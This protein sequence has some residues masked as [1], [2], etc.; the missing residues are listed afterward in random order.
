MCAT[1]RHTEDQLAGRTTSSTGVGA[2]AGERLLPCPVFWPERE[3]HGVRYMPLEAEELSPEIAALMP[4]LRSLAALG[5]ALRSLQARDGTPLSS[6]AADA[7][8][9]RTGSMLM[10]IA[11]AVQ[12]ETAEI[13][14]LRAEALLT[15]GSH[16][17]AAVREAELSQAQ[18]LTLICGP[19][20][21]FRRKT[22]HPLHTVIAA[23]RNR[24]YDELVTKLD[25]HLEAATVSIRAELGLSEL[26]FGS[27]F[28]MCVTDLI[29]CGGEANAYPKHF[30]YFLPE[31]EGIA[32]EPGQRKKTVVF[33]NVYRYRHTIISQPLGEALLS[34]PSR[35]AETPVERIL[36]MW[37][38]GHDIGHGA[39]LP[40][41]D[42]AWEPD[43]G[44]EPFMMIQEAL[45]DVFG[46][47]LAVTPTWLSLAG[48]SVTDVGAT[49]LAELLHYLR[50]GPWLDGDAGAAYL[51]LSYLA[52]N[53]FVDIG[54]DGVVTWE[55]ERL[56]QGMREL[57][58]ALA[59]AVLAASD[60]QPCTELVARYGWPA[61][62][63][64]SNVLAELHRGIRGVPTALAYCDASTLEGD[65]PTL[66]TPMPAPGRM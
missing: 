4:R 54:A 35:A 51:E 45:A 17:D 13:V 7:L 10:E 42:Y 64:A 65:T 11:D 30:A 63:P 6:E 52:V 28:P 58:G 66:D 55:T 3:Q 46:F 44:H 53:G 15:G 9:K 31:D 5:D 2:A 49:F 47:M 16:R 50:R 14:R 62:T 56:V 57:A 40:G 22:R 36:L 20:C 24:P 41:T 29:A 61:A 34:G 43:L 39:C 32:D 21:T 12:G 38:R 27:T 33:R 26:A 8:V 37:F 19:V 59:V 60:A 23:T 25:E 48:L 1:V 18:A